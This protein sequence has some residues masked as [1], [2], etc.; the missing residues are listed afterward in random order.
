MICQLIAEGGIGGLEEGRAIVSPFYR[1]HKLSAARSLRLGDGLRGLSSP[2]SALKEISHADQTASSR[3]LAR[4]RE[5]GEESANRSANFEWGGALLLQTGL[6]RSKSIYS[7][8]IY[9]ER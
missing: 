6:N 7:K 5:R 4:E 8:T 9:R 3:P 1:S 2:Q